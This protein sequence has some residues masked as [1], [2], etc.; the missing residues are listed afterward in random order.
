[1]DKIVLNEVVYKDFG[2]C[3]VLSNGR[4]EALCTVDIG[5]RIIRFG[6]VGKDNELCE[7][8]SVSS[9]VPGGEYK[10]RGGH[11]LWHAPEHNIRTYIPDND[12]VEWKALENGILLS[13]GIEAMTGIKKDMEVTICPSSGKVKI[14]HR[15]T[16]KGL[17][18]VELAAW[19]ITMMAPGGKQ[20]MPV[21]HRETSLLPNRSLSLWPYSKM[22]DPRVYWGEKY[23]TLNQDP[24]MK[25]PF[26][27][28]IPNEDGWSAY[29][30]HNNMFIKRFAHEAGERYLDFGSS[31]ETYVT[32]YMM[33]M[34]SL[35]PCKL[36]GP[37]EAVAHVE[38]WELIEN[39]GMFP[40]NEDE[41]D[42]LVNKYMKR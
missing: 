37:G 22:N 4:I 10:F 36:L 15:L 25:A 5:P 11:R 20:F 12:P 41:I 14:V 39:V 26:K 38:E 18:P 3:I 21:T 9:V 16:N 24:G 42:L 33:E 8:N 19:S 34:E 6:F 29:I 30:N 35:S 13:Q 1:M 7:N 40:R 28:G 23:I 17:W 27:M 32:D 31:Y 2:K